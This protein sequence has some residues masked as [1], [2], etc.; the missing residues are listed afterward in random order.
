MQNL[1]AAVDLVIEGRCVLCVPASAA[2]WSAE[3]TWRP[4][5]PPVP[6]YPW[7]ILW[8][9]QNPSSYAVSLVATARRLCVENG[10][11]SAPAGIAS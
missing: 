4:L 11:R 9:A 10:W 2:P 8:R 5:E 1:R 6:R 3:V 7:S